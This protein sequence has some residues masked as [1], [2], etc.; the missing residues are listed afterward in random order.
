VS[1]DTSTLTGESVA[2]TERVRAAVHDA[3]SEY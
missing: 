2:D 1:G 3:G